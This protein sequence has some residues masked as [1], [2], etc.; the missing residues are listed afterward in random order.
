MIFSMTI[1]KVLAGNKT[2]TT[3][4]H[5]VPKYEI[6]KTYA[7]QPGRGKKAVCRI[8]ITDVATYRP[9]MTVW[10]TPFGLGFDFYRAEGFGSR[11]FF[12]NTL[13]RLHPDWKENEVMTAYRFKEVGG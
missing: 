7:A 11:A 9:F 2:V 4:R 1:D 10:N 8:E 3:R 13:E 12:I 6:G 5:A